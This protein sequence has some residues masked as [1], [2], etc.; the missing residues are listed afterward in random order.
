MSWDQREAL[1]EIERC[2]QRYVAA[3]R[4]A[5]PE[6][7]VRGFARRPYVFEDRAAAVPAA[8]KPSLASG[9]RH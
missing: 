9:E 2:D 3:L 8:T 6:R 4:R 1:K 7:E 5:H